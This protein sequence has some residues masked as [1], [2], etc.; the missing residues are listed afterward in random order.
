MA[1]SKKYSRPIVVDGVAY[2]WKIDPEPSASEFDYAGS[3]V[4][5]V[6]LAE[7][8]C[9]VLCVQCGLR[10]ENI[11]GAPGV[12]VT[13]RRIAAAIR[14]AIIAGWTP[15]EPGAPLNIHLPLIESQES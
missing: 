9:S 1:I 11:L 10:S 4:A 8:P 3:M 14:A 13:P 5:Y 7:N 15:A 2:R 6:Q 12:V